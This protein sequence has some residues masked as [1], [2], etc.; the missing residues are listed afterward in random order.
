VSAAISVGSGRSHRTIDHITTTVPN[1]VANN[2]VIV[3]GAGSGPPGS[4]S[5]SSTS[6]NSPSAAVA[7]HG[8]R[9]AALATRSYSA[10]ARPHLATAVRFVVSITRPPWTLHHGAGSRVAW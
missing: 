1:S 10:P 5:A 7:V 6:A 8:M 3:V 4:P 9:K 2:N